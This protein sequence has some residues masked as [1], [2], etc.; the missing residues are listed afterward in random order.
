MRSDGPRVIPLSFF[1][2]VDCRGPREFQ[3]EIER[4]ERKGRIPGAVNIPVKNLME[5]EHK[6]LAPVS[7]TLS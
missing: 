3:G 5:G 4:G 6:E 7:W 1:L 2:L